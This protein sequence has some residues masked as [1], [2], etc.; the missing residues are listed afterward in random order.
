LNARAE[1]DGFDL[2]DRV[3]WVLDCEP[4]DLAPGLEILAGEALRTGT[5]R[6]FDDEGISEV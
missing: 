1:D 6:R 3:E 5:S 2:R 4:G